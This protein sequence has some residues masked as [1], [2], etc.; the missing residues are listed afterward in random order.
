MVCSSERQRFARLLGVGVSAFAAMLVLVGLMGATAHAATPSLLAGEQVDGHNSGLNAVS[1]ASASRCVTGGLD[2]IVQDHGVRSDLT[3][4]L[5][6]DTDEISAI[7]CAPGTSVCAIGDDSGGMYTLS[8][9]SLSAR[10]A[11]ATGGEAFDA[12]SCPLSSF[13][14]AIDDL[15]RVYKLGSGGWSFTTTLGSVSTGNPSLQ[16]SCSSNSFCLATL[17]G[18][19]NNENYYKWTG[20][21]WG[22]AQVLESTGA[23]ETGLSCTT[24]SFCVATDTSDVASTFNGTSWTHSSRLTGTSSVDDQFYVSCAGTFCLASSFQT[25]DT[26]TTPDGST[27]TLG[28]NIKTANDG[29][30]SGGPTSCASATMCAIVD[31]GGNGYTYALPDTLVTHPSLSGSATVGSTISL[32]P[33]TVSS[34]DA[35]VVDSFQRCLGGCT[36]IT[37]TSYTPTATDVGANIQDSETTG[38]GLNIEKAVVSNTIGPIASPSS[39]TPISTPSGTPQNATVG[40]IKLVG[41][42]AQ[43]TIG[44]P[45]DS[46]TSCSVKL[47]LTVTETVSGNKVIAIAAKKAKPR[48]RTVTVGSATATIQPGA[49]KQITVSL[50][51]T[52]TKLLKAHHR[53]AVLLAVTQS[54]KTLATK[55]LAFNAP[56]KKRK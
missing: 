48:K 53:L 11:V 32:T 27:W 30:G 2:L 39:V 6:S 33:G 8:G 36:P 54:N 23:I 38:V 37:G 7:S 44:C 45:A 31:L 52:G 40:A 42:K 34:P 10:S 5:S 21:S 55:N 15:G 22:S 29:Y 14:M 41:T 50:N 51:G 1:C 26:L 35:S 19:G 20:S 12:I 18:S 17:P 43:V 16:V 56:K 49:T 46:S 3:S 28:T 9:Q 25:A 4:A 47:A 24:S 13:C